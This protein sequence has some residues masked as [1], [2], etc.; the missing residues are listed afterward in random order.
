MVSEGVEDGRG[1]RTVV[2]LDDVDGL[3]GQGGEQQRRDTHDGGRA[4]WVL[5]GWATEEEVEEQ[6][7]GWLYGLGSSNG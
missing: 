7:G 3:D 2:G 4:K 6:V 1:G 5:C